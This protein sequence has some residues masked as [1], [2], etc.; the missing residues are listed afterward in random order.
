MD[1]I[2]KLMYEGEFTRES[3]CHTKKISMVVKRNCRKILGS[4]KQFNLPFLNGITD[5]EF[6]MDS[7]IVEKF[8]MRWMHEP[9][10]LNS[11][12]LA[13]IWHLPNQLVQTP[14]ICWVRSRKLEPPHDLPTSKNSDLTDLTHIGKT[15]FRGRRD[16]F[17][18]LNSL[19]TTYVHYR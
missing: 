16:E 2:V 13:T 18:I 1:K 6:V 11:E 14:S 4:F 19:T 10:A 8:R 7:S 17:G 5:R 15:D 9:F 3:M 12:E